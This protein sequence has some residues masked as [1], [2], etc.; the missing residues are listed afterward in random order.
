MIGRV[1]SSERIVKTALGNRI[2]GSQMTRYIVLLRRINVSGKN[3][4]PMK[5]LK[6]ELEKSSAVLI[7]IDNQK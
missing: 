7:K 6:Q 2:L 1:K 5:E 3:K 4:I